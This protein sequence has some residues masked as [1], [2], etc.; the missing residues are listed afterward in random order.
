MFIDG[1]EKTALA[2]RKRDVALTAAALAGFGA[3]A[4]HSAHAAKK[5]IHARQGKDYTP[6]S[7]IDRHP[8]LT[9]ALSL[10]YAPAISAAAHQQELD[11][12][13]PKVRKVRK[14]H[15]LMLGKSK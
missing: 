3:L 15:P 1:F 10:G 11:D 13:N 12:A 4:G 9:G 7:F 5:L 6:K 2:A 8:H 14:E